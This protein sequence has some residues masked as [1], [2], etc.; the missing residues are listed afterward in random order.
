MEAHGH[1]MTYAYDRAKQAMMLESDRPIALREA[2]LAC[3]NGGVV[4]V[5]GVY[6]GFIDKFPM[7]AVMNRSLT[8]RS[9]QCHVQRYMKPLLERIQKGEIDPSFVIT[10]RLSLQQAARGYDMFLN[11]EDNCEK[12]VL[13]A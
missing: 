13:S 9:G 7:G 8:I 10:H 12:V 4:S 6:G 3:R 1:G 11:K 5:I 2:I